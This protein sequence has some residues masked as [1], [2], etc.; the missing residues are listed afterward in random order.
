MTLF[1]I[2]IRFGGIRGS[3]NLENLGKI[4]REAPFYVALFVINS[5]SLIGFPMTAGFLPKF[6]L[7]IALIHNKSWFT[8]A[9][10]A[11]ASFCAMIYLFKVIN[12]LIFLPSS[13]RKPVSRTAQYDVLET[14]VIVALTVVNISIG[15]ASLFCFKFYLSH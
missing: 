15:L 3:Y 11:C 2:A 1:M 12:Q 9:F 6:G 4:T 8:L 5:F 10:A 14:V 13:S 7:F